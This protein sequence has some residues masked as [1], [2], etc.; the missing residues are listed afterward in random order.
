MR[1]DGTFLSK[2]VVLNRPTTK[3]DYSKLVFEKKYPSANKQ[4]LGAITWDSFRDVSA[5]SNVAA[6]WAEGAGTAANWGELHF[7][8]T[9]NGSGDLPAK[10]MSISDGRVLTSQLHTYHLKSRD[11]AGSIADRARDYDGVSTLLR[12]ENYGSKHV[13]FDASRGVAPDGT[14]PINNTAPANPE[15]W[16]PTHPCL[17]G[18]NGQNTFGVRVESSRVA[19][20]LVDGSF[21]VPTGVTL[22]W[23]HN[24]P[25]AGWIFLQ[26]QGINPAEAPVLASLYGATLPDMRGMYIS[27]R[28]AGRGI[29]PG[30][31]VLS[32]QAANV[33]EHEH[34]YIGGNTVYI[35]GGDGPQTQRI[36]APS[37]FKTTGGPQGRTRPDN[38]A[39]NYIV[40][41]G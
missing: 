22:P 23:P 29:D 12:W 1:S 4:I 20:K 35:I 39:F 21:G 5:V 16:I 19:D 14:T 34:G 36:P 30:R 37:L 3:E 28:D 15:G 33:G 26:G 18:W 24:T 7:G 9:T 6:I 11:P 40:R 31:T 25:P 32:Y 10:I 41:W 27:G 38:I 17:M 13:I 8:V 2:N